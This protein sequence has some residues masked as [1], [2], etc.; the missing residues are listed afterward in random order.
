MKKLF[1]ENRLVLSAM[2]GIN[3]AEFCN[4]QA[5]SLVI[6]GGFNADRKAI[7]A[8]KAVSARGRKEFIF[9]DPVEGIENEIKKVKKKFAINVRSATFEGYIA[10]AE[11]ASD[12]KGILEINAHCRQPEFKAIGCGEALLFDQEKLIKIIEKV[13][14]VTTTSVKIRGGLKLDYKSLCS[15]IFL[16]G[17]RIVHI[18]AMVPE[19][20]FDLNLISEVSKLGNVVGNNSFVDIKSGEE[21]IKAGAKMVSAARA[22]LNDSKFFEKML[23]SEILSQPVEM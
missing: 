20:G 3:D 22:V 2:A 13:S 5:A 16:A 23:K 6:L 17:A 4:K 19:G 11:L 7:E 1:F 21:Y 18:D 12:Y 14:E 10:C 8:A 9:E 15:K